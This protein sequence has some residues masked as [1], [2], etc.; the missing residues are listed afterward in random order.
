MKIKSGYLRPSC[1]TVPAVM[2]CIS[3]AFFL[4]HS[5]LQPQLGGAHRAHREIV[6]GHKAFFE[7]STVVSIY[8]EKKDKQE[9]YVP[10]RIAL[11]P[12]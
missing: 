3:D 12:Q 5:L 11:K 9:S 8:Q 10:I 4:K 2:Y 7:A 1:A 6:I